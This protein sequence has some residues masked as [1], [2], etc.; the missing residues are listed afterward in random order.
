L[1]VKW[2]YRGLKGYAV[3]GLLLYV[4]LSISLQPATAEFEFRKEVRVGDVLFNQDIIILPLAR[5]IFHEQTLAATDT[6]A[7]AFS[8]L[9][10]TGD[11]G[12]SIAQT[13]AETMVATDTGLFAVTLPFLWLPEYPGQM[14]GDSPEW[15]AASEPIRFAGMPVNTMMVFPSMTEITRPETDRAYVSSYIIDANNSVP[16]FPGNMMLVKNSTDKD[17]KN[18]TTLERPPRPYMTLFASPEEVAEKMIMERMWRNVHINYQLDRAYVGETCF[19][20]L[21]YPIKETYTLMPFPPDP[22]SLDAALNMTQ[23]GRH[24]RRIFWTVGV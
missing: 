6:E 21:I 14:I 20:Q 11:D 23:G 8:P 24:I 9:S 3:I 13:S 15:A 10:A 5:A 17:G 18:V 22:A 1:R 7:F 16:I 2:V 19:P 4:L 12:I